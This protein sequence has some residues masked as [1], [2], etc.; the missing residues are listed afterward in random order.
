VGHTVSM[1]IDVNTPGVVTTITQ[2]IDLTALPD[3]QFKRVVNAAKQGFVTGDG[4]IATLLGKIAKSRSLMPPI[5]LRKSDWSGVRLCHPMFSY[6]VGREIADEIMKLSDVR[7]QFANANGTT[8]A[9]RRDEVSK[10]G[11]HRHYGAYLQLVGW[12]RVSTVP[13]KKEV[14]SRFKNIETF[15]ENNKQLVAAVMERPRINITSVVKN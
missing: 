7:Q 4:Y 14:L 2:Q 1:P 3:D 5:V 9:Y 11:D 13:L 12:D 10:R 8:K 15:K 6:G